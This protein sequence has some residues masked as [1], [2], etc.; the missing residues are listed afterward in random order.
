MSLK[1]EKFPDVRRLASSP[2]RLCCISTVAWAHG[3]RDPGLLAGFV[4]EDCTML[5]MSAACMLAAMYVHTVEVALSALRAP[6]IRAVQ[7][8]INALV[9]LLSAPQRWGLPG[10]QHNAVDTVRNQDCHCLMC[11]ILTDGC[12]WVA[13]IAMCLKVHAGLWY[14]QDRPRDTGQCTE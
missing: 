7:C 11:L 9:S 6:L 2:L 8:L 1:N 10:A 3:D 14:L 5:E 12:S 4:L 13:R